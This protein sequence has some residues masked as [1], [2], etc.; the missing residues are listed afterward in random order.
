MGR[1][2]WGH[3]GLSEARAGRG[4]DGV[5]VDVVLLALDGQRV[6]QAQHAQLGGAV[7]GLA[8]VAVDAGGRRRHNDPR[9]G[10]WAG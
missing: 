4:R 2:T 8:K 7:V 3:D 1:L 5:A 10:E 6:G 9:R